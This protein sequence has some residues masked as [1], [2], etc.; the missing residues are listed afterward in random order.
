MSSE[1]CCRTDFHYPD[2]RYP[3]ISDL[4]IAGRTAA[5]CPVTW[6]PTTNLCVEYEDEG[7]CVVAPKSAV[8]G[9]AI[10]GYAVLGKES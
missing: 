5:G 4:M 2:P 3:A 1:S 9:V 6:G 8:L 10:L 7:A